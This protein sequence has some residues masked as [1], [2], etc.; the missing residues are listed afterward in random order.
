MKIR[1]VIPDWIKG[2]AIVL[3]VYGH[4][5]HIGLFAALQKQAV[6]FIY[7]FH[8]PLF[9][10]VSGFFFNTNND[11]SELLRK[12]ARRLLVP[13]LL[14]VSLYLTGLILIQKT[15]IQTSNLPPDSFLDFLKIVFFYPR[16]VYWFNCDCQ[17]ADL[18][19]K[20]R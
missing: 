11:P 14:F 19:S 7:T 12:L 18:E 6:G 8:I 2:L 13:Y 15:G 17:N 20:I 16:G 4:I 5:N 9:L 3:M 1:Q 10:I